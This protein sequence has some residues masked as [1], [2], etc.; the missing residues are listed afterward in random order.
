MKD[1]IKICEANRFSL[2]VAE[3]NEDSMR[4]LRGWVKWFE[5]RGINAVLAEVKPHGWAVY[6][7]GLNEPKKELKNNAD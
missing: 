3:D 2:F 5:T 1:S 6:R 7:F 4:I